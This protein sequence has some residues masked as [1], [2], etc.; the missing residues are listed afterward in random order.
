[1]MH[2]GFSRNT[3]KT[4]AD[5]VPARG[6]QPIPPAAKEHDS[7][8]FHRRRSHRQAGFTLTELLVAMV[9]AGIAMS[10]IYSAY[11][12]QQRAYKTTEDVTVVQQNLRSAMYFLEKDLRMAGYDPEE[13]GSFKFTVA[14]DHDFKYTWDENED[15]T[16]DSDE[17]VSYKFESPEP[18]LER[19]AGDGSYNDIANYLTDV[20]FAYFA[21]SGA[22]TTNTNMIRSVLVTMTGERGG[23]SRTLQTR[24][25]CRNSGL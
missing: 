25:W 21:T 3:L 10:A 17:Y 15:G 4:T 19:D 9:L 5:R 18:T 7:A 13:S 8:P 23:H 14:N 1:M 22:T 11:V 24:I 6:R 2:N 16:L 12:T 20:N